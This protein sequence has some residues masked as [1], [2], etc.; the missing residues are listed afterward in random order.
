MTQALGE[1]SACR[2][3][4]RARELLVY[5]ALHHQG[6][7]GAPGLHRA[8]RGVQIHFTPV[9]WESHAEESTKH[10]PQNHAACA[11]GPGGREGVLRQ[12]PPPPGSVCQRSQ[13]VLVLLCG[14]GWG[15]GAAAETFR[16][17][18]RW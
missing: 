15:T 3:G 4:D 12:H 13:G 5:P 1:H 7:A 17:P 11:W 2:P 18:C 9:I 14:A 8:Q 16:K 6:E 10:R